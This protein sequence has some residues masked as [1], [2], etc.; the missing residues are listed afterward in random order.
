MADTSK[1][2]WQW[3]SPQQ[4]PVRIAGFAWLQQEGI[5]RR[6]P[7]KANYPLPPAVDELAN[8]TAGGQIRFRTNSSRLAIRVRLGDF[9]GHDHMPATAQS[10]FDCYIGEAGA[11]RYL[12]TTRFDRDQREY[13]CPFFENA[14]SETKSLTLNFPL[15]QGVEEVLLGIEPGTALLAPKPY[16]SEERVIFYGTSI[17]Q[18]GCASRPGMAFT[19]IL[20][21]RFHREF[22]N[23]GFSGAGNGQAEVAHVISQIPHP[24]CYVL[25]YD[26]N[27]SSVELMEQTLPVFIGILR[28]KQPQ[29]PILVISRLLVADERYNQARFKLRAGKMQ[30]QRDIVEGL[31]VQG[32]RHIEFLDGSSLMGEASLEGTVDGGHPT[33]L[34]FWFM[35]NALTPIIQKMLS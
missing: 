33:D 5:Y 20:S 10:G 35:A 26:A 19:N 15:Y 14:G 3:L 32:D 29:T 21:R 8:C 23:L 4:A 18:G 9:P 31:K 1:P 16:D 6:M 7:A 25:D 13:E 2:E 34:G 17:T 28:E 22:I 24:A 11:Q 30:V 27:V 12:S